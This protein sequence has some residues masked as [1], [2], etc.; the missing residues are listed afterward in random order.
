MM[1]YFFTGLGL[2]LLFFRGQILNQKA[3]EI[4]SSPRVLVKI[5]GVL[6][7]GAGAGTA[8]ASSTSVWH[9]LNNISRDKIQAIYFTFL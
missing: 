5:L 2:P 7:A 9:Y 4:S 8:M 3:S 1:P 6:G